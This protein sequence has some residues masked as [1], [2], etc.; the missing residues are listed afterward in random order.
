MTL[1]R[2]YARITSRLSRR[3]EQATSI[4]EDSVNGLLS[5]WEFRFLAEALLS[6]LWIDWNVFVKQ[7]LVLSCK[8]SIARN[9]LVVPARVAPDNSENRITYEVKQ[10]STGAKVKPNTT[11]SGHIEPTWAH[12]DRI[13]S[14]INGLAPS[15]TSALQ[16]AFGSAGLFG[17]KRIHLVRNACAHKSKRNRMDVWALR[18]VYPTSHFLDPIDIIWGSNPYT[19]SIAIFEWIEDLGDIADLATQ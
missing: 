16:N 2:S 17:P 13:V 4:L 18:S 5:P 14:Y 1:S 3:H 15:N 19:Y 12:P 10:L 7:V 6:N 9:G 11:F 8:G